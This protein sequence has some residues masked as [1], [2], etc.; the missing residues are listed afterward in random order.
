MSPAR[1]KPLMWSVWSLCLN[2][3]EIKFG[4]VHIICQNRFFKNNRDFLKVTLVLYVRISLSFPQK[5]LSF[6][7]IAIEK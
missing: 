1:G 3:L 5:F 4:Q 6:Y 7:I 2:N